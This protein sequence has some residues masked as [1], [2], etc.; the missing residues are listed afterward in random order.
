VIRY[1]AD[2]IL[3][4]TADPIPNSWIALDRGRIVALGRPHDGGGDN[5]VD[6]GRSVVLPGLVNAHTHLELSYLRNAVPPAPRFLDWIRPLMARRREFPNPSDHAILEHAR[7][8]IRESR[9]SGT[10][11]VGDVSNTLV[12]VPLLVDAGMPGAVFYELLKFNES[13]PVGRVQHARHQIDALPA[14]EGVRVSIA[15]HAPYSVAPLLFRAIRAD[16]D[17]HPFDRSTVHLSESPDEVEFIQRGTG[18]WKTLLEEIGVW[19]SDW[20]PPGTTPVAYLAEAGFLDRRV[21][22][23]HGVQCTRT[24]LSRLA[25][26]GASIVSCPRSNRHVGVGSPPLAAF[27]DAGLNVAFGTDSLAS[28]EDLNVFAELAEARRLAPAVPAS[29]LLESATLSGARAL[30]FDD[31]LGSIDPGKRGDLIAVSLPAVGAGDVEEYLVDGV[32]PAMIRW[33]DAR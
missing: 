30:G 3:P 1:R 6:L 21:L 27:Y 11:L 13:D 32:D 9:A 7:T 10:A 15:P 8:G 19:A 12:T 26:I 2:W 4:I 28:V 23:V 29:R 5:I 31:E 33:L 22:V 20:R 16:L 17:R 18:A 14:H 25:S 24:D